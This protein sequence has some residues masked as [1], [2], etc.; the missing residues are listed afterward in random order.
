MTLDAA[1]FPGEGSHTRG[2]RTTTAAP[3][4]QSLALPWLC[5]LQTWVPSLLGISYAVATAEAKMA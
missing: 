4:G 2:S 3:E 1:P 5:P